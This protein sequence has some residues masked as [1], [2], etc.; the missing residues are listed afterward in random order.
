MTSG[1]DGA[2]R[3]PLPPSC[4]PS[5]ASSGKS[6]WSAGAKTHRWDLSSLRTPTRAKNEPPCLTFLTGASVASGGNQSVPTA[7]PSVE[8][9]SHAG[10]TDSSGSTKGIKPQTQRAADTCYQNTDP[11]APTAAIQPPL[12]C[13]TRLPSPLADW[14]T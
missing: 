7:S 10:L 8:G 9:G 6:P 5:G 14:S 2:A 3:F 4:S 11:M 1:Q 13:R 12:G